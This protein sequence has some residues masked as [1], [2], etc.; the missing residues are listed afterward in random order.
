MH[1]F[2]TCWGLGLVL[3]LPLV[4]AAAVAD[5]TRYVATWTRT[6]NRRFDLLEGRLSLCFLGGFPTDLVPLLFGEAFMMIL[7]RGL[8]VDPALRRCGGHS[9]AICAE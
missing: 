6:R 2:W 4:V 7:Y 5:Q 1:A 9:S 3:R 8:A